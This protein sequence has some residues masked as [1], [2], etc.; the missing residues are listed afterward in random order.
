M[1]GCEANSPE[2]HR[3]DTRKEGPGR[4]QKLRRGRKGSLRKKQR[5]RKR[6]KKKE[7]KGDRRKYGIWGRE[8]QG[9]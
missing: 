7:E 8:G 3:I 5:S 6:N 9:R 4:K 1:S 2:L